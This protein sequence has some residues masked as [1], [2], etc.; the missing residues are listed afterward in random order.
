MMT[1]S[2]FR[3]YRVGASVI[4]KWS[5][6]WTKQHKNLTCSAPILSATAPYFKSGSL[7]QKRL[8]RP[9]GDCNA[10]PDFLKVLSQFIVC[11]LYCCPLFSCWG[12]WLCLPAGDSIKT[13]DM[14][15]I[16][17]VSI[18]VSWRKCSRWA[19]WHLML[20]HI[21]RFITYVS[22][23]LCQHDLAKTKNHELTEQNTW[24]SLR[25]NIC[26]FR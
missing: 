26:C 21:Q 10:E 9:R 11:R 17:P 5:Q 24:L 13:T 19:S 18:Y 1:T 3:W 8:Q 22:F 4:F 25:K 15:V 14:W 2:R 6:Q 7:P 20:S 12:G 16:S 23:G